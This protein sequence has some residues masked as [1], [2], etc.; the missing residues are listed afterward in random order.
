MADATTKTVAFLAVTLQRACH[1]SFIESGG[2][3]KGGGGE[4]GGEGGYV[5]WV[6]IWDPFGGNQTI[7]IYGKFQGFPLL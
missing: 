7:E 3:C 6:I 4:V 2:P 5:W 1:N